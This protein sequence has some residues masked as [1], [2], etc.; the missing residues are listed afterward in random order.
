MLVELHI[1]TLPILTFVLAKVSEPPRLV[2]HTNP[3]NQSLLVE[4]DGPA[5]NLAPR[6]LEGN[7]ED[8]VETAE[9]RIEPRAESM[10]LADRPALSARIK[11]AVED[12]VAD[13]TN[14]ISDLEQR[15]MIQDHGRHRWEAEV[16]DRLF[17]RME[18]SL[19]QHDAEVQSLRAEL[20][21]ERLW[22]ES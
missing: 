19:A 7:D 4:E 15:H 21:A 5:K 11:T 22:W 18:T 13:L 10:T 9:L 1:R 8:V 17:A 20:E 3:T 12:A 6:A 16:E 14:R 2:N